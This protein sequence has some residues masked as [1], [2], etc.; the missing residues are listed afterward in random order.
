[1]VDAWRALYYGLLVTL[2][3]LSPLF[4]GTAAAAPSQLGF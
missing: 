2:N 3:F 4:R 1:M